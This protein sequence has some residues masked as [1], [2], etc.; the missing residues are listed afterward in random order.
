MEK[1]SLSSVISRR[2]D[3]IAADMDGETVM[4]S[5]ETGQY[6]NLGKIGGAIWSSLNEPLS[7]EALIVKLM[8]TYNVSRDQCETEVIAF[9]DDLQEQGLVIKAER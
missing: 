6:Y 8:D 9:L 4:M 7:I 3:I 5:V 2:E 1:L